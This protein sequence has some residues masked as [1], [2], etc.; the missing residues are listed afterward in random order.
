MGLQNVLL[1]LTADHGVS[2]TPEVQA[3][4][5]MPGGYIYV[6]IEDIVRSALF[7]KFGAQDLVLGSV[8]NAVY[9]DHKALEERRIDVPAAYHAAIEALMAV[10]QAHVARVFTRDQLQQGIAGDRVANA[11]MSGFYPPRSGDIIVAFEPYWMPALKA[12]SKTTHFS[13]YNYDTHV[14]VIF[15]GAGVRAGSYREDIQVND[16]AP[17]LAALMDVEPPAG[18]FGRVLTEALNE[19]TP[20]PASPGH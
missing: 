14:P 5:K 9:L 11:A 7:K 13:P 10:P 4:R 8:D 1:V 6:D 2:P 15:L 18:A 19:R 12:P 3:G 20:A 17:T 16:I